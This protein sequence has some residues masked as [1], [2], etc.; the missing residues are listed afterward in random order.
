MDQGEKANDKDKDAAQEDAGEGGGSE[1]LDS[2]KQ[3][4][5]ATA[6][7]LSRP[8][9]QVSNQVDNSNCFFVAGIETDEQS[10]T[11]KK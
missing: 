3:S 1:T 10:S 11:R 8:H 6:H 9:P 5:S 7:S 2:N 4:R